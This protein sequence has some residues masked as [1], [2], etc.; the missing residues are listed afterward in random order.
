M[1]SC[2]RR[3]Y[4]GLSNPLYTL[5]SGRHQRPVERSGVHPHSHTRAEQTAAGTLKG[6]VYVKP[7]RV[8]IWAFPG[9]Y[10]QDWGTLIQP[11]LARNKT[12]GGGQGRESAA[13]D[14]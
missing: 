1:G 14:G 3:N 7:N 10:I 9:A 13:P 4:D 5:H 8:S 2:R 11:G 12:V 6:P